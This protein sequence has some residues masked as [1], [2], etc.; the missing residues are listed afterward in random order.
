MSAKEL[1]IRIPATLAGSIKNMS[2]DAVSN[3]MNISGIQ[4]GSLSLDGVSGG[5]TFDGAVSDLDIDVVSGD[6]CITSDLTP[7]SINMDSVSGDFVGNFP[8]SANFVADIDSVSGEFIT[9]FSC[10]KTDENT[11]MSGNGGGDYDFDSVS[12]DIRL[13]PISTTTE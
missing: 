1:T 13:L 7:K 5:L 12:G 2:I 6:I 8:A 9:S 11:Y 4:T 10:S 3:T